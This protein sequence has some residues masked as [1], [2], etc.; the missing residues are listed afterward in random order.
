M[1][2]PYPQGPY[3]QGPYPQ[4]PYQQSPYQQGPYHQGPYQQGPYPGQP[5]QQPQASQPRPGPHAAQQPNQR[6]LI[7]KI[8]KYSKAFGFCYIPG[9]LLTAGGLHYGVT[10]AAGGFLAALIG[11][12][13]LTFGTLA[14]MKMTALRRELRQ[15]TPDAFRSPAAHLPSARQAATLAAYINGL[16][17]VL[18]VS[19]AVY[20]LVKGVGWG[21]Y[22][23]SFGFAAL[24]GAAFLP[25]AMSAAAA[26]TIP[27][28]LR[29]V[30]TG[31]KVGRALYSIILAVG[32]LMVGKGFQSGEPM[33]FVIGGIVIVICLGAM[34]LLGNAAKRMR[35]ENV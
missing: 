15:L 14:L 18:M 22:G 34:K 19:A 8:Q 5:P 9:I 7:I 12:V 1:Q 24:L 6:S 16:L 17:V 13:L 31:A 30:P 29:V 35:G 2:G 28:L 26:T 20:L 3:Q 33:G 32:G 27:Q 11:A 4:D 10:Q 23:N 25:L 21:A